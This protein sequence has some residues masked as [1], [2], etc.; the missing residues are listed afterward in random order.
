MSPG[1]QDGEYSRPLAGVEQTGRR[2]TYNRRFMS[3]ESV[4]RYVFIVYCATVGVVLVLIPWSPG[5]DRM[6]ANLPGELHILRQPILRGG[7]SGFGL[8]HLVWCA[9][10]L[11]LLLRAVWMH[12]ASDTHHGKPRP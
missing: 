6:L 9:H 5:W 4:L 3:V 12:D 11:R 10:D 1:S 7:V 8:V 2:M